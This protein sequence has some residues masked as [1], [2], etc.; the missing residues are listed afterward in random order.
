MARPCRFGLRLKFDRPG[1]LSEPGE[2]TRV[3]VRL[4]QNEEFAEQ[5]VLGFSMPGRE[6]YPI[7]VPIRP[8]ATSIVAWS[9]HTSAQSPGG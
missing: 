3:V 7:R 2:L 9:G 8:V 6:G 4:R 5:T 1:K